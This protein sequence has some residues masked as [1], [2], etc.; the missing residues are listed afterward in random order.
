[1]LF[2]D[3]L[4]KNSYDAQIERVVRIQKT[5][6]YAIRQL[7]KLGEE[8][9]QDLWVEHTPLSLSIRFKRVN[10]RMTFKYSLSGSNLWKDGKVRRYSNIFIMD[11]VTPEVI[12]DFIKDLRRDSY[13]FP[14]QS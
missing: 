14:S 2:W 4:A 8:L 6:K 12:D 9:K 11:H 10:E 5:I 7:R 3:Y 13:P 1:M